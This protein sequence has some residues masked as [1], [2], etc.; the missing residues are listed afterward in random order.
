M[1]R[2]APPSCA[3]SSTRLARGPPRARYHSHGSNEHVLDSMQPS[4]T[5][6]QSPPRTYP[7]VRVPAAPVEARPRPAA[8]SAEWRIATTPQ[9]T[10]APAP[11]PAMIEEEMMFDLEGAEPAPKVRSACFPSAT[12]Q[13]LAFY[14]SSGHTD[15]F[16]TMV[17]TFTVPG[18]RRCA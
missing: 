18:G 14:S 7:P 8:S 3:Y 5:Q 2:S 6:C 17:V 9:W 11:A 4:M 1:P 10:P 16:L 13:P 12:P 15:C